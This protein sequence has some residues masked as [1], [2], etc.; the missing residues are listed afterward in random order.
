MLTHPIHLEVRCLLFWNVR[1]LSSNCPIGGAD[2]MLKTESHRMLSRL[3]IF[4]AASFTLF[5]S[6]CFLSDRP[7]IG[8]GVHLRDGP[9]ALCLERG[10]PCHN[11]IPEGDGYLVMPHPEDREDET[12]IFVRFTPLM[13]AG[14]EDVWLGEAE[15]TD[16]NDRA[17]GYIVARG[18]TDTPESPS[19]DGAEDGAE[20]SA[21]YWAVIPECDKASDSQRIRFGLDKSNLHACAVPDL[22]AFAE[23]LAERHGADFADEDWWTANR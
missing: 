5:A 7:L 9:L 21:E 13:Q 3:R 2:I 12:P 16:K 17:W 19:E 6:A 18:S 22:N 23:Y 4:V 15:L 8:E 1:I 14:G 10:E 11:A 20:Y